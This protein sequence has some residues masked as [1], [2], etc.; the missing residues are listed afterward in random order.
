MTTDQTNNSA[1]ATLSTAELSK[2]RLRK[3]TA[4]IPDDREPNTSADDNTLSPSAQ[5]MRRAREKAVAAGLKQFNAEIPVETHEALKS[6]ATAL[7][8]GTPLETV[9][10]NA[11]AA[12]AGTRE[13]N[14]V[15]VRGWRLWI[16]R[17]L[18]AFGIVR[19]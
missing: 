17:V 1:A 11:L 4:Y 3:T 9:L 10:T 19:A 15:D 5:R 16:A 14:P 6:I 12:E 18:R 7:K 2:L 13:K 8:K